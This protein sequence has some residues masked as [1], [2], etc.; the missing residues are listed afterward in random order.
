MSLNIH[1]KCKERLVKV[2]AEHLANIDVKN[3]MFLDRA[4][5]IGLIDAESILPKSGD[6]KLKLQSC[7][8]ELPLFEFIYETLSRELS[9]NFGY[10]SDIPILKLSEIEGYEDLQEVSNRLIDEFDSLPWR[11]IFSIELNSDLSKLFQENIGNFDIS[12]VMVIRKSDIDFSEKYPP[13]SGI[14]RR[15][16]SI[17]GNGAGA[18]FLSTENSWST[19]GAYFQ[20][21]SDGFV[22]EYG[23]AETHTRIEEKLK[24]FCGLGIALR[25]FKINAKYRS[26]PTKAKFF[27]HKFENENWIIQGKHELDFNI[28]D[29]FHDLV[30]HDLDGALD[31]Q[32]KLVP[33]VMTRL[34]HIKSVF[35]CD[36]ELK[37]N[38]L[39]LACQWLFESFSGKNELLSF[40]QTTVVIEILLGDKASSEQVGLGTLLRNRCAYLIGTSQSQRNEILDE[41]QK[42]YD[43]R[44]KIVHGGKSRLN[45]VERGLL[46]K[47]QWMCRRV[48]QEEVKLLCEDEKREA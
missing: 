43:V 10:D 9:E 22:G 7:I 42:I 19:S 13:M 16:D 12:D 41:F 14:N 34:D 36:D 1:E 26:T 25:L 45:Y 33:W 11:Y 8:G 2:I 48:I 20:M 39:L 32:E 18:L 30:I 31:T 17:S 37:T 15:D 4:S 35:S 47:L 40:V 38:K 23:P 29:T 27:I 3:K 24:S 44:S 28:S 46:S 6:I 5:C 21:E